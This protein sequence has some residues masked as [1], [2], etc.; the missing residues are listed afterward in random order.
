M[1]DFFIVVA[2]IASVIVS[3]FTTFNLGGKT[4]II[5]AMRVCRIL[6]L[7]KRAKYLYLVFSTLVHTLPA[8]TNIGLLLCLLVYLYSII[9]IQLFSEVMR[10][11]I[12]NDSL[13]F[14]SF[15]NAFVTLIACATG[16][17][18]SSLMTATMRGYELD[19]QCIYNPDYS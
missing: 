2:S 6:R 4:I 16:D 12:M 7:I 9:G 17:S 11:G 10:N 18:T 1:F 14:E 8:M 19:F 13:N 15:G 3:S 5:R